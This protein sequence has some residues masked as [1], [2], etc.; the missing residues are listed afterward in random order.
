MLNGLLAVQINRPWL[1][2]GGAGKAGMAKLDESE[3]RTSFSSV[4]DVVGPLQN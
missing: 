1:F 3:P 2:G 4:N